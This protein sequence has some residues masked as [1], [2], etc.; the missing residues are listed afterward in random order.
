MKNIRIIAI[1]A[2]LIF[3]ALISCS[4]PKS[5]IEKVKTIQVNH[6]V[7]CEN[8]DGKIFEKIKIEIFFKNNSSKVLSTELADEHKEIST[9]LMCRKEITKSSGMLF[10]FQTEQNI[11]FWMLN[12]NFPIDILYLIKKDEKLYI[13]DYKKMKPCKNYEKI[14][15]TEYEN[16]CR[17]ES[18]NYKPKKMYN[19][20][21]EINKNTLNIENIA[22]IKILGSK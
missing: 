15:Y 21:L 17:T 2:L 14:S 22:Y 4:Q 11:G 19:Y 12:V 3:L 1:I 7:D 9:G 5:T 6:P 13:V 18:M 16:K 8:W 10:E 20:A